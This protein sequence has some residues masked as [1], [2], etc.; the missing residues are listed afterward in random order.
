MYDETQKRL[1]IFYQVW[2]THATEIKIRSATINFNLPMDKL[3]QWDSTEKTWSLG[4]FSIK[5][6]GHQKAWA[7]M[8]DEYKRKAC[9]LIGVIDI[10]PP[11]CNTQTEDKNTFFSFSETQQTTQTCTFSSK[12]ESFMTLGNKNFDPYME[13]KAGWSHFLSETKTY[14]VEFGLKAIASSLYQDKRCL[15]YLCPVTI[16]GTAQ[17]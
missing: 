4:T 13:T 3:V 1:H 11:T 8:E 2:T 12:L 9:P 14:S 6:S 7:D 10:A 15:L 5:E 17:Q 16:T